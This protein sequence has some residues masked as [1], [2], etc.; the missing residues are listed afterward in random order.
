[1]FNFYIYICSSVSY[2]NL[3]VGLEE[4]FDYYFDAFV[5]DYYSDFFIKACDGVFWA[6]YVRYWGQLYGV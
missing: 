5:C 6:V 1:M 3:F 4:M 2:R